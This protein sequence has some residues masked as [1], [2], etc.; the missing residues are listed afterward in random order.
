[1]DCC[2]AKS[3][4]LKRRLFSK[5]TICLYSVSCLIAKEDVFRTINKFQ[6]GR[7]SLLFLFAKEDNAAV[8]ESTSFALFQSTS[9]SRRKTVKSQRRTDHAQFQSTS[10]SRRKTVVL[11]KLCITLHHFNPLPSHEGRRLLEEEPAVHTVFQSTSFSRR[12]TETKAFERCEDG[13][14]IHFLLTKEDL[15]SRKT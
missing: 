8:I 14:S 1:M 4:F 3:L 13:I 6:Q 9:F 2:F 11:L 5:V 7:I 12:K 10:F 15:L